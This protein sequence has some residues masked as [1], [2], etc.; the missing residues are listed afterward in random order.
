MWRGVRIIKSLVTQFPPDSRLSCYVNGHHSPGLFANRNSNLP[1]GVSCPDYGA[2]LEWNV[3]P[4]TATWSAGDSDFPIIHSAST[5][6]SAPL[7]KRCKVTDTLGKAITVFLN[8]GG[9]HLRTGTLVT[10]QMYTNWG[11]Y[12]SLE[13]QNTNSFQT[14]EL[15]CF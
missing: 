2:T 14:E 6:S 3:L 11:Q 7:A 9:G 4:F 10:W 1:H 8:G 12:L 5:S 15:V 13:I